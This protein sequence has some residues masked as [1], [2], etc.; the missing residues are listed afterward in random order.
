MGPRLVSRGK[1]AVYS[2]KEW[3]VTL[4]WGRDLLVAERLPTCI[5]WIL[6]TSLQWGR[7]LL[8]AERSIMIST[9]S[10]ITSLQ[11]G[12]DLLVAERTNA[13]PIGY[14]RLGFNGAATC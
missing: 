5:G 2:I 13:E 14:R 3:A 6:R 7:D 10:M 9:D 11:W 4:Q 12:R 1:R 8:V